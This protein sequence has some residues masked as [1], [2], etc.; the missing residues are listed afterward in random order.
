[1]D[2]QPLRHSSN[3]RLQTFVG[4]QYTD[5]QMLAAPSVGDSKSAAFHTLELGTEIQATREL[6]FKFGVVN[7]TNTKRDDAARALDHILLGRTAYVGVSYR[8]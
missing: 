3:A 1:M 8:L 6:G 4:Y 2:M 7:L 5:S